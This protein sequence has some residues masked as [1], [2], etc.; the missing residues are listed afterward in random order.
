MLRCCW[1]ESSVSEELRRVSAATLDESGRATTD[2][3]GVGTGEAKG[4]G[5]A[6][7]RP[8]DAMRYDDG[9]RL[10]SARRFGNDG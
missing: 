10:K 2:A 7:Q 9:R 3:R 5:Q 6:T 4:P 8:G 1:R